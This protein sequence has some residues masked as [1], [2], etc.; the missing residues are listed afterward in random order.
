MVR[1]IYLFILLFIL[2][3]IYLSTYLLIY[4]YR[5]M[6][7]EVLIDMC[8]GTHAR[9][10]FDRALQSLPI[11]Q[12][13]QI[14]EL[15]LQWTKKFALPE[16]S[17]QIY[18]RYLQ[19]NPSYREELV[20]YLEEIK[21]YEEAAYQLSICVNDDNFVPSS[22]STKHQ[23]WMRLCDMCALHPEET[24]RSLKVDA[25][26]RSGISRFT[27]EVG[28]LWTRLAD[29]YIRLGQF[30]K[31]RDI[32]EESINT[33]I[34]V[35]DFTIVFDSYV[36]CEENILMATMREAEELENELKSNNNDN[37]NENENENDEDKK[38]LE[39][40]NNEIELRLAR[41]EHITE[42]RPLLLN[43]VMLRQNPNN[44]YEWHKRIKLVKND[45]P[46]TIMTFMEGIKTVNPTQVYGK[47]SSLWLSLARFYENNNDIENARMVYQKSTEVEYRHID[48][49][50][51]IW[52]EWTE[53]ELRHKNY[54]NA[55]SIMK[56]AVTEPKSSIQRKKQH[57]IAQGK[58]KISSKIDDFNPDSSTT[59]QERLH[60]NVKIWGLYLDLEESLGSIESCRAA[61][62]RVMDM[63]IITPQMT[64]NYALFLEEN[65]YFED[66]FRVY[67][68]A[69]SLFTFPHVK[70]IWLTYLDKFIQR[71][72][73]TKLERLRD[74]FEQSI[75]DLPKEDVAE[76][77]IKYGLAEEEYGLIRHAINVYDR[78]TRLVPDNEKYDMYQLYIRKVEYYYGITKT[79]PIYERAI[80]EFSDLQLC[81]I[82]I[83]YA[84]METKLGEIDR[85][86]AIYQYGSQYADPKKYET[87]WVDWKLFEEQYGNSETFIDLFRI[88]KSVEITYS[89]VNYVA[90]DMLVHFTSSSKNNNN[91]I[92]EDGE[93][94]R[95]GEGIDGIAKQAELNTNS[96]KRKFI[97]SNPEV[98]NNNND[99]QENSNKKQL[100]IKD[101]DEVNIDDI[102]VSDNEDSNQNHNNNDNDNDNSELIIKQKSI[103][104]AIYGNISFDNKNEQEKKEIKKIGAFDR[105][106][107]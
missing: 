105:F 19:F 90:S 102:D 6:Y 101:S 65:N 31:A 49:L 58:T 71:Y 44:I 100:T 11:T 20:N 27:D 80:N 106:N 93:E 98:N 43:S 56:Q 103:P 84:K 87:Y 5:C 66:S 97:S 96:N 36:K 8:L 107:S 47:L 29:Y 40:L 41:L 99:I 54:D 10:T 62:D 88:Q 89:Q 57:L 7:L 45:K 30:E 95:I 24:S 59:I 75:K 70:P 82:C 50:A 14:W 25:I 104:S 61:Y 83:E 21:L 2:L 34:T 1:I 48:E 81:N 17:I 53:M 9:K 12:H 35:R 13:E 79:R 74:L 73:G 22:G 16:T 39:S 55:L 3:F 67:E 86:R 91:N 69:V 46:R 51:T 92:Q 33:V 94:E 60:R 72:Q 76:F 63:K 68:R 85:A 28:R 18:R 52:C 15:Y 26:V 78:A 42:R 77:Y 64:L 4:F 37:E 38:L 32:Y 23:L